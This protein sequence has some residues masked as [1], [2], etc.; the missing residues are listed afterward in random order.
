MAISQEFLRFDDALLHHISFLKYL[1][2]AQRHTSKN[3]EY[4][5]QPHTLKLD[6]RR[7][8]LNHTAE[9]FNSSSHVIVIFSYRHAVYTPLSLS[10]QPTP[11]LAMSDLLTRSQSFRTAATIS[12]S[13]QAAKRNGDATRPR[14]VYTHIARQD[15]G[16]SPKQHPEGLDDIPH[17]QIAT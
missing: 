11:Q 3:A 10:L 6:D 5:T 17:P 9:P 2:S 4:N 1:Q 16:S 15:A 14:S 7:H 8:P 13:P 12:E